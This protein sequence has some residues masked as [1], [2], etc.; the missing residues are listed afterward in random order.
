MSITVQVDPVSYTASQEGANNTI[1]Y[2]DRQSVQAP[3]GKILVGFHLRRNGG[4]MQYEYCTATVVN[5]DSSMPVTLGPVAE[6]F[7]EWQEG[8]EQ[9][10]AYL[11]RQNI[12]L[13]DNN[14]LV[15]FNLERTGS[16]IRYKYW[17]AQLKLGNRY[18]LGLG[19]AQV[20]ATGWQEGAEKKE[21][22]YLDR[23]DVSIGANRVLTGFHLK[24]NGGNI[25]YD[26][27][28]S[29]FKTF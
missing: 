22:A 2:L 25:A 23:H 24:R 27:Y 12:Q 3:A 6:G 18:L 20:T 1:A 26:I 29:G 19:D 28:S 10:L 4:Q 13:K 14:V 15:G 17:Y 7:T 5:S 8:A 21:P 16:K 9:T 11:D